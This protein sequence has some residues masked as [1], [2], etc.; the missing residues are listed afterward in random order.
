MVSFFPTAYP[1]ELLYSILAR[2]YVRSANI[3]PK[4]VLDDLFGSTTVIATFDLPSHLESLVSNLPLLSAHTVESFIER[5]TLFPLYAP[6]LPPER[7]LIV[8]DSMR[9]HFYGDIHTRVGIMASSVPVYPYFRFCPVCLRE[10]TEKYGEAYWHRLYQIPGVLVC[11]VH[12]VLLQQSTIKTTGNNR[13]E[14]C[15]ADEHNCRSELM[16]VNYS[17]ET[18]NKLTLLARDI[19]TLLNLSLE[20]KSAEWYRKQYQNLLIDKRLATASGRIH[21]KLLLQEFTGF[22]GSEF[23]EAVHSPIENNSE[24]NWLSEIVRKHRKTFHPIRHILLIRFLGQTV[25][26]F[27]S[28]NYAI[29]PFGDGP[30]TCFNGV[31]VHYLKKVIKSASL[32]YSRE[33]KKLIGTFS[34]QCGFVYSTSNESV[35]YSDKLR[36]G[37]IKAFGGVWDH[38]LAEMLIDQKLSFRKV[39]ENLKVD[40]KTVINH[41]KRLNLISIDKDVH[42]QKN[43]SLV[44]DRIEKKAKNRKFWLNLRKSQPNLSKTDLRKK[45]PAVYMWLYRHDRKWLTKNS[46]VKRNVTAVNRR[47]DWSERDDQ[48]LIKVKRTVTELLEKDPPTRI[49]LSAVGKAVNLRSL[50]EKH[51]SRLPQTALF[52]GTNTETV[53]E[54]QIRRVVWAARELSRSG[55]PI[56]TWMIM[57]LAGIKKSCSEK[58]IKAM[59]RELNSMTEY[60]YKYNESRN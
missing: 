2:Y 20:P 54:F 4:A 8:S 16:V 23:L 5:H 26:S 53:E 25:E 52:L 55:K 19:D 37:K 24:S 9:H 31:S 1:D 60:F 59:D 18:F 56:R 32:S 17:N 45:Q 28:G 11:P 44:E 38:K 15:A 40:T 22:Y 34:C 6:F 47:V 58:V 14:F 12:Y 46:P 48:I 13:H 41:A 21:Q 27:F 49:T 30:W 7:A 42:E 36:F 3:S 43:E 10:E 35:P 50:L 39:A 29:K 57:R 33:A 51:L